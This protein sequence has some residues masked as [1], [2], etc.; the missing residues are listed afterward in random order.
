[1]NDM[2]PETLNP[3]GMEALADRI[4][5]TVQFL[6]N[7]VT[8]QDDRT[9]RAMIVLGGTEAQITKAIG[10]AAV[11]SQIQRDD[12]SRYAY[13]CLRNIMMEDA[14]EKVDRVRPVDDEID[15]DQPLDDRVRNGG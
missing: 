8:P 7:E 11:N 15:E 3:E 9:I 2:A 12:K 14:G 5:K 13:G 4:K 1:M 6:Y 10:I